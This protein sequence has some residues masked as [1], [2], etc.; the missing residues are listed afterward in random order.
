MKEKRTA[1]KRTREKGICEKKVEMRWRKMK[2]ETNR[3]ETHPQGAL[4][5]LAVK[6]KP[7]NTHSGRE[8]DK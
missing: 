5:V 8:E 4:F 7:T 6:L 2:R 3:K 1:Q